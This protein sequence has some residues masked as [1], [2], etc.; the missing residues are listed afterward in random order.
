MSVGKSQLIAHCSETLSDSLTHWPQPG[1][2]K[3]GVSN[4]TDCKVAVVFAIKIFAKVLSCFCNI[5]R[6]ECHASNH[7]CTHEIGSDLIPFFAFDCIAIVVQS[8][9]V[10]EIVDHILSANCKV[11]LCHICFAHWQDCN[12]VCV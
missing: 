11:R 7:L 3:V 9:D 2:I 12:G 5:F 1:K 6:F 4:G 10:I 8:G